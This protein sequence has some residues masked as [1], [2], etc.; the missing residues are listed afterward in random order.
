[1]GK[2]HHRLAG[3]RFAAH[4]VDRTSRRL[5]VRRL[6]YRL[7]GAGAVMAAAAVIAAAVP[8]VAQAS[9]PVQAQRQVTVMTQ[10]L[11]LGANLTPL[12]TPGVDFAT[13][14]AAVLSHVKQVDFPARAA[15][16]ADEVAAHHPDLIGLQE[17]ALWQV[18]PD[19][20]HLGTDVDYQQTLLGAL[21]KDGLSYR[22]VSSDLNFHL[23]VPLSGVAPGIGCAA[24]AD[25]DVILARGD[26]PVSQLKLSN[27]QSAEFGSYPPLVQ[28]VP[29]EMPVTVNVPGLGPL[30]VSID[31]GWASVDVKVRGKSFRFV[32]SHLEAY[33]PAGNPAL[34]RN[35]QA[36][37]L[38]QHVIAPSK[39]PVIA[40][41]DYNSNAAPVPDLTGAYGILTGAGLTDAWPLARHGNDP[42]YT[43]GQTDDLNNIPSQIDHRIDLVLFTSGP[44]HAVPGS[45]VTVGNAPPT[46][47]VD[48]AHAVMAFSAATGQWLWPS[49]HAGVVVTLHL[50][51]P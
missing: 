42:G 21:A 10:K 33:G 9:A 44:I 1:M 35:I 27:P 51:K 37:L 7:M 29:N 38:V 49:D 2:I 43:S 5:P 18:G 11:Y 31:R 47:T 6:R 14:A 36:A 22:V 30:T 8:G 32:D 12:F 19:C 17:V 48:Q 3:K 24:F 15:K 13:A 16:I 4:V 40:V 25:H 34:F 41:G 23:A 39:L 20:Q 45:G 46:A 28:G 26:L 50:A